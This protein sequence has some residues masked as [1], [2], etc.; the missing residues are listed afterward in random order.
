MLTVAPNYYGSFRCIASACRHSCCVGW[1]I[2]IDEDTCEFYRTLDGKLSERFMRC[3]DFDCEQPHFI[4]SEDERCPFL[5]QNGLCD[6]I[7]EYGEDALCQIC[8][9]HPRFR[10]F[11]SDRTEIGLGLCCEA[12]AD[13]IIN[14]TEPFSTLVIDGDSH[15]ELS[16][17]EKELLAE[18][19]YAIAIVSDRSKSI[20]ERVEKLMSAFAV[21]CDRRTPF[22]WAEFFEG[23]ERLDSS[24]ER[25]LDYLKTM[26][27]FEISEADSQKAENLL[28][29]FLYRYI[30]QVL[31]GA[32]IRS[33]VGFAVL[34]CRIILL[35]SD[36]S[37]VQET[38]RLY[39]SE[40]EYSEENISAVFEALLN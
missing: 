29:Y 32:D 39:S 18:R 40:I 5:N 15:E 1:E 14:Q 19:D 6:I 31:D 38:A 36:I 37:S 27:V 34:S 21:P 25:Y 2:D 24:W 10:N 23:L 35:L 20:G 26:S 16:D 12:A 4:L 11:F 13:L 22:Q 33:A 7:T 28:T 9:D 30:P 17:E 3:V 8:Y